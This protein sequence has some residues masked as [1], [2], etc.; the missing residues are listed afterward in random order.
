MNVLFFISDVIEKLN[1]E[2]IASYLTSVL[3]T[4]TA[5]VEKYVCKVF[6]PEAGQSLDMHYRVLYISVY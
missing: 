1:F 3:G 2:A 4:K 6:C 5:T